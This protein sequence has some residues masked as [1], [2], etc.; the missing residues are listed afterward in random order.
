[1]NPVASI[2]KPVIAVIL[3]ATA[4]F[5]AGSLAMGAP[6]LEVELPGGLPLGNM[7]TAL[8]LC[9]MVAAALCLSGRGTA[10]R[11]TCWVALVA[12]VAWLPVSV[13]LA[14]NLALNFSGGSG[15][16]WL[17][18]SLGVLVLA[19]GVLGWALV[20]TL[21]ARRRRAR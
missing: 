13:A 6:Y 18:L 3:L 9:A 17:V 14:G 2:P 20:A 15:F 1:M 4:A 8:G 16:A 21:L 7:L 10:L 5:A 11:A 19:V 12:A